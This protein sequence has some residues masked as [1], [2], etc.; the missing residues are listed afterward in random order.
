MYLQ[1]DRDVSSCLIAGRRIRTICSTFSPSEVC[2]GRAGKVCEN[3]P[4]VGKVM[5]QK[6]VLS[7]YIKSLTFPCGLQ[8]SGKQKPIWGL[9]F[10]QMTRARG[11]SSQDE[12]TG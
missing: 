1:V 11:G 12:S 2:Q 8:D 9:R 7:V 5:Q 10:P 4:V 3:C 6:L